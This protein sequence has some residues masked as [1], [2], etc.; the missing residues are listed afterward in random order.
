MIVTYLR[1]ND[2]TI[3][4]M[5]QPEQGK[6]HCQLSGRKTCTNRPNYEQ[7]LGSHKY[8]C[9]LY[10]LE[11]NMIKRIDIEKSEYNEYEGLFPAIF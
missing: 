4:T 6:Q 9:I 3:F 8:M 1:T 11:S 5:I 2:G 7:C 10:A